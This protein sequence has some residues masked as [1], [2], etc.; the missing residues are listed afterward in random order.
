MMR[1][2][3]IVA[4][5]TVAVLFAPQVLLA[6]FVSLPAAKD[7]TLYE[8][9]T[10]AFS[11][12]AGSHFFAG[13]T[14]GFT[15]PDT[16]RGLIA[17]DIAGSIPAGATIDSVGLTLHVS[18]T[19][20][21]DTNVSLH[22]LLA[23]WG[24]GASD[25]PGQEGGGTAPAPGDATWLHTASPGSFWASAGGDF[26]AA[27][28]GSSLVG[29]VGSYTWGSTAGMVADVQT[30]LDSGDNCGWLLMGNEATDEPAKRFDSRTN[31]NASFRPELRV[32][33]TPV[34][35]PSTIALLIG[36]ACSVLGRRR[37]MQAHA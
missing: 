2:S 36:G 24:E 12:G 34:P 32:E 18:R 8:S 14:G 20:A 5:L 15:Q 23:D 19:A 9:A 7:N 22:R 6:D 29:G 11:N 35:E 28:S 21:G 10:G 31:S 30:W 13:T 1:G 3:H 27:S 17:F 16:R 33:Y 4:L 37:V 25:A 26:V